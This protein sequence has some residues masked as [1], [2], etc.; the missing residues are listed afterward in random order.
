MPL[1]KQIAETGS[2]CSW[3]EDAGKFVDGEVPDDKTLDG[4]TPN[5]GAYDDKSRG[6]KVLDDMEEYV[7]GVASEFERLDGET[8]I[9]D[10]TEKAENVQVCSTPH[11]KGDIFTSF[12]LI[13]TSDSVM[14]KKEDIEV[15]AGL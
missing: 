4:R 3:S 12:E 2:L 15:R 11:K 13:A 9:M 1:Q 8:E 7:T 10:L 6:I 14:A 5:R